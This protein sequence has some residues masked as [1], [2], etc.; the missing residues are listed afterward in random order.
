MGIFFLSWKWPTFKA[1]VDALGFV[2][3]AGHIY[4]ALCP[5]TQERERPHVKRDKHIIQKQCLKPAHSLSKETIL[6]LS[7]YR[8]RHFLP[9][10]QAAQVFLV[11][12]TA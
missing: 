2:H 7:L 1:K 5:R 6:T 4:I 9:R 8:K 10:V 12:F 3:P 11:L